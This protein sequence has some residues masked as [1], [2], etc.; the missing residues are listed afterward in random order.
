M[1]NISQHVIDN[2]STLP[3]STFDDCK[4]VII[5]CIRDDSG[6]YGHHSYE[7]YGIDKEGNL[8]WCYSSGCSCDGSCGGDHTLDAKA[9]ETSW[10]EDFTSINPDGFN[11]GALQVDFKSY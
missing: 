6:D 1:S 11:F 8:I 5:K 10:S 7:G 4:V 2:W 3:K 9:F